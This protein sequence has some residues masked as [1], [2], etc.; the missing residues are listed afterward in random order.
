MVDGALDFGFF[1]EAGL[2]ASVTSGISVLVAFKHMEMTT[3]QMATVGNQYIR[4]ISNAYYGG[5]VFRY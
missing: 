2:E 4:F 1:G 3:Q 5:F